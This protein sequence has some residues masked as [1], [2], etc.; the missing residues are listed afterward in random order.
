MKNELVKS[1]QLPISEIMTIG[2]AFQESGMFPDVKSAAMAIVKIQ[3]GQELGIAPFAAMTGI[4]IILGKPT[5]GATL[6]AGKVKS[7]GK[8]DYKVKEMTDE[9]CSLD[10]YQGKELIGNSSFTLADAK[11]AGTKNIDKFPKN[12]LFA[13]A[14]SNGVKWFTPDVFNST[15]YTP[16]DFQDIK[17]EDA[18]HTEIKNDEEKATVSLV[19]EKEKKSEDEPFEIPGLWF[20]RMDKC[21]TKKD[22]LTCY[23]QYKE[24]IDATPE[25]QKLLKETQAKLS[26][27]KNIENEQG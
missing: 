17:T 7:S 24:T 12:M 4:H 23:N 3:A 19:K 11:R 10:F 15:V 13:R 8:Y 22:I 1:E 9:I 14:I 25:L 18:V 6:M 5:V 21:K 26:T 20:A 2:K 16:E 27:S